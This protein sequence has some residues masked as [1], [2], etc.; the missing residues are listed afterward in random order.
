MEFSYYFQWQ[1]KENLQIIEL[2]M[3]NC[4]FLH[5][6]LSDHWLLFPIGQ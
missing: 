2:F 5:A 6:G 1:L 4:G 3:N